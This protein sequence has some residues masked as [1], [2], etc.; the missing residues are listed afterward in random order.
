M[1]RDRRERRDCGLA[2]LLDAEAQAVGLC[3]VFLHLRNVWSFGWN[4]KP[5]YRIYKRECLHLRVKARHH[6]KREKSDKLSV[7]ERPNEVLSGGFTTDQMSDSQTI[8]ILCV[9]D[10]STRECVCMEIALFFPACRVV[11][12]LER[13]IAWRG[14]AKALRFDNGPEF[15]SREVQAWAA[16]RGI[17]LKYI[18]P[19]NPQQGDERFCD[20]WGYAASCDGVVMDV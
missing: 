4:H 17:E 5:V 3:S 12:A 7:P 20:A 19:G 8:R 1:K 16:A 10:N 9:V 11:Q 6:V 13:L 14:K 15:L 2:A 18:Q